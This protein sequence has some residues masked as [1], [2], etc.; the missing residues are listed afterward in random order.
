MLQPIIEKSYLVEQNLGASPG[1]Q[2]RIPFQFISEI[3]GAEIFSIQAFSIDDLSRTPSG[4]TVVSLA[5]LT[6]LTLTFSV[7]DKERI[8]QMPASDLRSAN[9]FGFQRMFKNLKINLTKSY[10]TIQ[11]ATNIFANNGLLVNFIYRKF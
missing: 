10:I 7:G 9:I 11:D 3:E 5:G 6:G 2:Q 1:N 4:L 8:Y